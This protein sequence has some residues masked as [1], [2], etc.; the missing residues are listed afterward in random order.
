MWY[1]DIEIEQLIIRR[2]AIIAS[3]SGIGK[4]DAE[5]IPAN[6]GENSTETKNIEYALLSEQIDKKLQS[7]SNENSRTLA[8]IGQVQ[9]NMLRGMLISRYLNRKTWT[10]IGKE[11][12]YERSRAFDYRK[13]A[14][15]AVYPFIPK[16]VI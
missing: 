14:L 6:T 12:N 15:D 5:F 4:Y 1:I 3:M 7:V 11:Y 9:D 8:V 13:I 10:Q 16:E 2:D